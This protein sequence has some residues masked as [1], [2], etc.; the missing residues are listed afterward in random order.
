MIT[1][2]VLH[3]VAAYLLGSISS[4]ILVTRLFLHTDIRAHGSGNP[5]AT[6]VLRLAGK[7]AAACVFL[8]DVLKGTIPVYIGYLFNY[9]PLVLSLIAVSACIGHM[10]PVFFGFSGGKAVATA[11]GAMMPLD[12]Y[13]AIALLVTWL[14]IFAVARISS[15]AAIG[16][17]IAVPIYTYLLKPEYTFAVAILCLLIIVKHKSNIARIIN[18]Q[19]TPLH[20]KE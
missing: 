2:I 4:A 12:W 15:I 8:F 19:E 17:L 7:R 11:L 20:K 10:Y 6:N 14:I 9:P 16:T 13:L 1:W 5:G 18:R 3:I